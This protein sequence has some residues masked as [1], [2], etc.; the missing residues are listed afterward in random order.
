MR[1]SES[2]AQLIQTALGFCRAQVLFTAHNL[3]VFAH[4]AAGAK[5]SG[6]I[7]QRCGSSPR[8]TEH[9]LDAC[10]ALALVEKRGG[11]YR[12]SSLAT[13][14][15]VESSPDYM[16]R[17]VSLWGRWYRPWAEL[18]QTVRTGRP[19]EDAID[20]LGRDAEYTRDFI[21]AMHEYARGPGKEIVSHVDLSSAT[22]LIDVG[23]GPGTY[24]ALFAQRNPQL[25][26]VVF[27]LPPVLPIAQEIIESYGLSARVAVQAGDYT[28]DSFGDAE[29][30]V[31]LM[32]NM[33]HQED[34]EMCGSLLRRAYVALQ[35]GGLLIVQ[36][37]FLNA[38]KDGPAWPTLQSLIL[39]LLYRGGRAYSVDETL[40]LVKQAGFVNA[41]PKRM[42]LIN[43]ES[44][45]LAQKA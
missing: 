26:A 40:D 20:H 33:L 39:N 31:V 8:H 38:A 2:L 45:I 22:R 6:E 9:L 17:W 5:T 25:K 30:D 43:A 7:A 29:Y 13:A 16:G 4:L 42:S 21:L 18:E 23:G 27:D 10:A 44:L 15:L 37:M 32:S 34:P 19:N 24:S 28:T 36:A 35:P 14:F 1:Q 12:N 11:E 3:G 41:R